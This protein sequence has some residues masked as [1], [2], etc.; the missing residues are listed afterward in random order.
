MT[1]E[2]DSE[3]LEHAA[4]DFRKAID[5]A[6]EAYCAQRTRIAL[7]VFR[8]Q[9]EDVTQEAIEKFE[10]TATGKKRRERSRWPA[11]E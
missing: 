7:Y 2:Q 11:L 4:G 10:K 8:K 9:V 6:I 5:Q 3:S 1:T